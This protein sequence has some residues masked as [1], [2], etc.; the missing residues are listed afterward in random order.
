MEWMIKGGPM[1]VPILLCSVAA[2]AVIAERIMYLR[3]IKMNTRKFIGEISFALKRNRADEAIEMCDKSPGPLP[4]VLKAGIL[5]Y[6]RQKGEI[7]EAIQDAALHE[8]PRI[9][10]NIGILA[11]LAQICPLL[12]LLG[13]VLGMVEIFQKIQERSAALLPSTPSDLAGG[14]WQ[15]LIATAAGLI[16]AIPSLTAYNYFVNKVNAIIRDMEISATDLVNI[17][18]EKKEE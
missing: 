10:K 17:L 3:G 15:A 7:K 8:I 18:S 5:K 2:F 14:I 12:G 1:M 6:D 9:E 13:T 16:V 4:R 11:T